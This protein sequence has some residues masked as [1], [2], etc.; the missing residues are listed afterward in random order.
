MP[1]DIH[2]TIDLRSRAKRRQAFKL[3]EIR[4]ALVAV[5]YNTVAKQANSTW[6]WPRYSLDISQSRQTRW[7]LG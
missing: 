2:R 3:A 6:R 5:G 1:R 4:E 7:P